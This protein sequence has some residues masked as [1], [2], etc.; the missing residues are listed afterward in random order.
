MERFLLSPH[1]ENDMDADLLG[2]LNKLR[3]VK[4]FREPL[5]EAVANLDNA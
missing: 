1:A 4:S 3:D 2:R 5:L